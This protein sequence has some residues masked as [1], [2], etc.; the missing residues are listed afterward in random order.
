MGLGSGDYG[1]KAHLKKT[2]PNAV[3]EFG[4][5]QD[6][7]EGMDAK[8]KQ[9][10][11][12]VDGNVLIR[13]APDG[14]IDLAS[15][16]EY[17]RRQMDR[18]FGAGDHVVMVFDEPENLTKAK[19]AEQARRDAQ[20]VKTASQSVVTSDD[21]KKLPSDDNYLIS[22]LPEDFSA[23]DVILLRG[24]RSRVF[25][26]VA[27][28]LLAHYRKAFASMLP[29][30]PFKSFTI[31]GVDVRGGDRTIGDK[32][33]SGLASTIPDAERIFR[34]VQPIGEGDLKM[35]AVVEEL[36]NEVQTNPDS[37]LADIALFLLATVDTDSIIIELLSESR[38]M[39]Q[40]TQPTVLLCLRERA[41]RARDGDAA[42]AYY[43]TMDIRALHGAIMQYVCGQGR[44]MLPAPLQRKAMALVSLCA[45]MCGTDFT[46]FKGLRFTEMLDHAK[47]LCLE[48]TTNL[49]YMHGAWSADDKELLSVANTVSQLLNAASVHLKGVPRR[50]KHC[51]SLNQPDVSEVTRAL[52][53]LGYWCRPFHERKNVTYWGFPFVAMGVRAPGTQARPVLEE[54][55]A[56]PVA[57]IPPA[58]TDGPHESE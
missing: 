54:V 38:R 22:D 8:A 43:T 36:W 1:V 39:E 49:V 19:A 58:F 27:C 6:V 16:V 7:R 31:D 45:I 46:Q 5:L 41:K 48:S 10:V 15:Y 20:R 37:P 3:F 56:P 55:D 13:S 14:V 29:G 24:A 51:A 33:I 53:N 42:T 21:I 18:A 28:A 34:R 26:H 52:W 12:V 23:H 47:E 9:T 17:S 50:W 32:R 11:V 35:T 2:F 25:D 40:A 57:A 44:S 4:T 30:A